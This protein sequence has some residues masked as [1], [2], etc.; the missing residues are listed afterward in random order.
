M[1][2][3]QIVSSMKVSVIV[4]VY[5]GA[6]TLSKTIE[7]VLSQTYSHFELLLVDDGS[8]DNSKAI[9]DK[10]LGDNR[11]KYLKKNN[12]GVASARN[13]GILH[14]SG[15]IVGFCDQDDQWLPQKLE[16][17]VPL[18]ND[19]S[20]GLVYSWVEIDR[21]GQRELSAPEYEGNCFEALLNRNFISC[22]TAIIR[23][24]VLDQVDGLD[25]SREL[26]G[27]D[28][29][30]LW[31]K[32]ARISKVGVAK[33]PLAIY[34]IHGENY[35][36]NNK[37]MLAADLSCIDKIATTRDLT[38]REKLLCKS[39]RYNAYKHY[40][41][42]F[43]YRDSPQMSASCLFS[44]WLEKPWHLEKLVKSSLLWIIPAPVFIKLKQVKKRAGQNAK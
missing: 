38:T 29:R 41:K 12:G 25:E 35:S 5:N 40:A 33:F 7:S 3:E 17:Q 14:A 43:E 30:H 31:L 10:Y 16:K 9:I 13:F 22:C 42:N 2:K 34:F 32:V 21:L 26:Q 4:A 18:F 1:S 27:V 24:T 28:D 39:A 44:A 20:I 15:D 23:K 19:S 36:L 6:K 8:Q 37:K 11:V